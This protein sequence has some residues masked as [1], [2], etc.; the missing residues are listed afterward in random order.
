MSC[1]PYSKLKEIRSG[2]V[3]M[4]LTVPDEEPLEEK[5]DG[6][7][8]IDSI[9][10]TL[11]DEPFIMNA[12]KDNETGEMVAVDVISA[13]KVTARFRN[14]AER[15]GYVS[16]SFDVTVP[17]ILSSSRWQL[18]IHPLMQ[19]QDDIVDLEPVFITGA[20]YRYGQMRGYE[21]Y[22]QFLSTIIT[23]TTDFIRVRQLEIFIERHF[24]QTYAMKTDSSFVPEPL[25]ANYFG[26]TQKE[27]LKH[28][29]RDMKKKR[30]ER[31]KNRA[32][33]MYS[34]YVKD[35]IIT[36]GVRLD[37]VIAD[38]NGDFVYRY[39][40]TF[41][42]RPSLRKVV[43]SLD[44][45]L[46]ENGDCIAELPFPDD[47][48]FYISSLATLSDDT[49]RYRMLILERRVLENTRAFIDF[50]Q[51]KHDVDT[52]LGNNLLELNKIRKC[53]ENVA[54]QKD[55]VLDSLVIVASC[56]PEG[57]YSTNEKLSAARSEEV[58]RI[59]GEFVPYEWKDSL[60]IS[61]LP[62]NWEQ[63]ERLIDNDTVIGMKSKDR[64]L[65]M[66]RN[67]KNPDE[68]ERK[69]AGLPEYRHI[70]DKIYP[71]LRNVRFDFH[72]HRVG[73]VKDTV[74]T[75]E[76]DTVYMAGLQALKELDYTTAV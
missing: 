54:A 25:A 52:S 28:Y 30:N 74:H 22:R 36:E 20:G 41:R 10:S 42:S 59:I 64:I 39:V 68:T 60:K 55:H 43:V 6:T 32:G 69:M 33:E 58:R 23:D 5:E 14:V 57:S 29:T 45:K 18:K 27:A 34:K 75:T 12:I 37:T 1:S 73:M 38:Y 35:P 66:I 76:L 11:A 46:Y 24:P 16:I 47:L 15:S 72:L 48:T 71:M 8:Q 19:I 51:G 49:P 4:Y 13:S 70:R 3:G 2:T 26:V 62:E 61:V 9:R 56:S 31:R 65:H 7:V 67:M 40:H 44:G 17:S 53:I 63:L 21:R 50:A